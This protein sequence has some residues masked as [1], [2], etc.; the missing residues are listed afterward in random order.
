MPWLAL[1]EIAA[2]VLIAA[3]G[4]LAWLHKWTSKLNHRLTLM[5]VHLKNSCKAMADLQEAS[6]KHDKRLKRVSD[7]VLVEL[8]ANGGDSMRDKVEHMSRA[9]TLLDTDK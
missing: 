7:I 2:T 8:T 1:L 4:V 6:E 9:I 5:D 3:G